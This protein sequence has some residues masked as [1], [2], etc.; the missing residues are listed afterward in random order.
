[1]IRLYD[2]IILG[3][4]SQILHDS[5]YSSKPSC[6]L[7]HHVVIKPDSITTKMRVIFDTFCHSSNGLNLNI[8]LHTVPILQADLTVLILRCRLR[9][10]GI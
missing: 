1:M 3:H 8:I 4:M 6:Y 5:V 2:H 7:P 9:C 10:I